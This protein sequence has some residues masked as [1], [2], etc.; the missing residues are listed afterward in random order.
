MVQDGQDG[1]TIAFV[2]LLRPTLLMHLAGRPR[3]GVAKCRSKHL[4][5]STNLLFTFDLIL[6]AKGSLFSQ[7][8]NS[9]EFLLPAQ[10]QHSPAHC[11]ILL[12]TRLTDGPGETSN[13][14][15]N[16]VYLRNRE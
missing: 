10:L 14:L 1:G 6:G 11:G 3:C 13:Q 15:E 12:R 8:G 5:Q 7:R 4:N 2:M 9:K 16:S